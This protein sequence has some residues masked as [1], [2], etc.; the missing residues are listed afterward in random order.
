MPATQA[1]PAP[2]NDPPAVTWESLRQASLRSG[3]SVHRI[4]TMAVASLIRTRIV[5]GRF[6]EYAIEDCLR[7]AR[8]LG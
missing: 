8:E 3:L 7:A 2:V 4:R 6:P 5:P 1:A